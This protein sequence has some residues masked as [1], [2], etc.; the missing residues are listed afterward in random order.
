MRIGDD[1]L[2]F[3]EDSNIYAQLLSNKDEISNWIL[4][5]ITGYRIEVELNPREL[6]FY[7]WLP[8]YGTIEAKV[9]YCAGK[10]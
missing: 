5:L 6:V 3:K 9:A 8:P 1:F 4:H 2:K 10:V 7:L